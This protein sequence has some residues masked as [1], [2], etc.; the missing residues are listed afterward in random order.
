MIRAEQAI[1]SGYAAYKRRDFAAARQALTGVSH[2]QAIHLLGL[3]E[4]NDG[5]Y[6]KASSHLAEAARLDP[7]NPEIANNQGLLARLNGEYQVAETAFRRALSLNPD[8]RSARLSLSRTLNDAGRYRDALVEVDPLL[9]RDP[10]DADAHI[11]AANAAMVDK[12][13]DRVRR[14]LDAARKS[15]PEKVS[16]RHTYGT[17]LLETGAFQDAI[18]TF[19]GLLQDGV[20]DAKVHYMLAQA[21]FMLPDLDRARAEAGRAFEMMPSADTLLFLADLHRMMGDEQAFDRLVA[22]ALQRR[23][24]A[25]SALSIMRKVDR[26]DAA[27]QSW[28]R[29]DESVRVSVPG[30]YMKCAL[31]LDS[32][33]LDEALSVV[34][35]AY[36]DDPLRVDLFHIVRASLLAGAYG[37]A[38]QFVREMRRRDPLDQFWLAY[39]VTTLRLLEDP[40]YSDLIDYDRHVRTYRLDPPDGFETIEA[41]N[42]AMLDCLDRLNPF[43]VAPLDQSL[44]SGAQTPQNLAALNDPVLKAYFRA[45]DT[46]IR[47]YMGA[48]GAGP[49][50]P[51]TN[52][53]TGAYRF[54]GSWSVTLKSGGHHVNHI[55]PK[56][57]IS[58]AY[59]VS[60]PPNM[61][62][63]GS[64][65]GWIKFGEPPKDAN[66]P[67]APEK[68]IKPQAGMLVLFPSF[69]WHGTEPIKDGAVRVTAPFD[70]VP[71]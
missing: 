37:E 20:E 67:L 26:Y 39:E 61:G 48:I 71:V 58:S 45:L 30:R 10:D 1:A 25:I 22:V 16:V 65:A 49:D 53:N 46:P 7:N 2:P 51:T 63:D 24:L 32:G 41:F 66:L 35:E 42:A 13:V 31:L 68:W 19:E 44:R 14:H 43:D 17:Y 70:I 56:G 21:F 36:T 69:C 62:A 47:D 54:S 4:K 57:W 52:R 12:D 34:K 3:V 59:Y 5:N 6:A 18:A 8:F 15:A 33:R 60:V 40:Q 50:H 23:E 27:L 11:C 28:E 9:Q 38:L 29:L 64:K 55:H